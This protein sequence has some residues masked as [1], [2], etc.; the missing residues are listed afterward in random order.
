M[1]DATSAQQHPAGG[2]GFFEHTR[3]LLAA[4]ATYLSARLR[5][6]GAESKE[7]LVHYGI[8]IGLA[9]VALLVVFLG[10]IFLCVGLVVAIAHWL[11]IGVE[12][13][14]LILALV[15]FGVAVACLLLARSRL[16]EPMFTTTISEFKKDNQ[17]LSTPKQ[18]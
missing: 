7:A 3:G 18:N 9:V 1:A 14:I 11:G 2:P 16:A 10:Y 6:A 12:Y 4:L 5:L 17:W 13:A 15:H 8:I